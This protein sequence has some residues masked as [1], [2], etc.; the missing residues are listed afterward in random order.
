MEIFEYLG[1]WDW[2]II[3]YLVGLVLAFILIHDRLSKPERYA[4][5]MALYISIFWP[6]ALLLALVIYIEGVIYDLA[7]WILKRD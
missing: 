7:N 5:P 1:F 3:I 2:A 6:V 4:I